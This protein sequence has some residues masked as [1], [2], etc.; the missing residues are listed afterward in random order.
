MN[1]NECGNGV[2]V[3]IGW[4]IIENGNEEC[5]EDNVSIIEPPGTPPGHEE[6]RVYLPSIPVPIEMS[7][8]VN[9]DNNEEENENDNIEQLNSITIVPNPAKDMVEITY[10]VSANSD[11][12]LNLVSIFGE[13]L[14]ILEQGNSTIN[15]KRNLRFDSS[16]YP[17][18]VYMIVLTT[19][20]GKKAKQLIIAK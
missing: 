11:Y 17:S 5:E 6:P 7:A 12:Q 9:Q 16:I 20:K 4:I 8:T 15:E 13:E 19:D 18:G 2:S 1:V 10:Q 3:S 14:Q